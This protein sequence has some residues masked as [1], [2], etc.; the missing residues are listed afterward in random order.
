MSFCFLNGEIVPLSEAKISPEDIGFLRGYGIFEFLYAEKGKF[1]FFDEHMER[2]E[3]SAEKMNISIPVS[4]KEIDITIKELMK[5]NNLE[6]AYIKIVLTGGLVENSIFYNKSKPT[7]LIIT[8]EP[9]F[10]DDKCYKEGVTLLTVEHERVFPKVKTTNYIVAVHELPSVREK[11]ALDVLYTVK[12]EVKES[13]T[14][15]FFIVKGDTIITP[16]EGILSGITRMKVLE[17]AERE[18]LV[19]KR[20]VHV[21]ELEEAD[22]AFITAT[23]KK[24]LPVVKVDNI[25]IGKGKV[26]EKTSYLMELYRKKEEESL[27]S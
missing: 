9:S 8:Q 24:V 3:N 7:L 19:E 16:K 4:R 26:G 25:T 27:K 22:E 12:G 14:S 13:S 17:I 18:F 2:F 1:V 20:D 6:S 15:N 23:N 11:G 10:L 5:R 21:S